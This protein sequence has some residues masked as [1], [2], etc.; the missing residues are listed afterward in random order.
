[1]KKILL[2]AGILCLCYYAAQ[3]IGLLGSPTK[4]E[5]YYRLYTRYV[6][7]KYSTKEFINICNKEINTTELDNKTIAE[8]YG[9]IALAVLSDDSTYNAEEVNI[10]YTDAAQKAYR[11]DNT[12]V[13]SI[14]LYAWEQ[15]D[16]CKQYNLYKYVLDNIDNSDLLVIN[17]DKT[18]KKLL[19]DSIQT[20]NCESDRYCV[21]DRHVI[22]EE[23]PDNTS[24]YLRYLDGSPVSGVVENFIGEVI[25]RSISV[26]N[27]IQHGISKLYEDGN[28]YLT[29][30]V[31]RG[32][33]KKTTQYNI[34]D[35]NILNESTYLSEYEAIM[36]NYE[37]GVLKSVNKY[38]GDDIVSGIEYYPSGAIRIESIKDGM[39][40]FYYEN[41]KLEAVYFMRGGDFNGKY[42]NY[43][44]NGK[45]MQTGQYEYGKAVG[46]FITYYENGALQSEQVYKNDTI[47][48]ERRYRENGKLWFDDVQYQDGKIISGCCVQSETGKKVLLTAKDITSWNNGYDIVC[49]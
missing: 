1:M 3:Y 47:I 21:G 12:S 49:P 40:K 20:I 31:D 41:G 14:F 39:T 45:V 32:I 10:T 29:A 18:L 9:Y 23:N 35:G 34:A 6:N 8:L 36:K 2:I 5:K 22:V 11:Y 27:G 43:Y 42:E 30:E 38:V 4:S 46:K 16:A 37:N 33:I 15:N 17:K 26:E 13:L 48:S 28:L 24:Y 7:E 19:V 25:V 44:E